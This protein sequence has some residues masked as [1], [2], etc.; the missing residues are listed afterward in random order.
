MNHKTAP[1][2][3]KPRARRRARQREQILTT[4]RRLVL[5]GGLEALTI[6]GLARAL[7]YTPGALYR[8]RDGK[9]PRSD[10]WWLPGGSRSLQ[11][12]SAVPGTLWLGTEDR[13][14]IRMQ[15]TPTTVAKDKPFEVFDRGRAM[16]SSWSLAVAAKSDG[17][18]WMTTP[19]SRP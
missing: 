15:V 18:A 8:I 7:D 6:Q 16:P 14:A 3:L 13:G 11:K 17:S 12:V 4:A 10:V 9:G 19:S 5:E 2:A 1:Q